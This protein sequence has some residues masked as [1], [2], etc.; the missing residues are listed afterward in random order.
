MISLSAN[1]LEATASL[2]RAE[3]PRI[4]ISDTAN[5][6]HYPTPSKRC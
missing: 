6:P 3:A 1:H 4:R 2:F 5:G